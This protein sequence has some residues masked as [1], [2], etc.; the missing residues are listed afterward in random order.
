VGK[1]VCVFCGGAGLTR[2][3]VLPDWLT[4]A[5]IVS[6]ESATTHTRFDS[7]DNPVER[8]SIP[9]SPGQRKVRRFCATCNGG[10]M[11]R[12]ETATEPVLTALI[13]GVRRDLT[14]AE[15]ETLAW[16]I[17]KTAVTA[18]FV[19]PFADHRQIPDRQATW[20][21]Q[22]G[23]PAPEMQI[24]IA[25]AA[26]PWGVYV[27]PDRLGLGFPEQG[28]V[29]LYATTILLERAVL[30][31]IGTTDRT[32]ADFPRF[33]G[34]REGLRRIWPKP[35]AVS[36]PR[37]QLLDDPTIIRLAHALYPMREQFRSLPS[38]RVTR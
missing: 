1:R 17:A 8:L 9:E 4:R 34:E 10:W 24:F 31:V 6:F 35:G 18:Q 21:Y 26:T 7:H 20:I 22:R 36:L 33:P 12:L 27:A 2:E 28:S 13:T 19:S 32:L 29:V 30:H 16:W 37:A 23:R 11:S 14:A 5:G 3:H 15:V 25:Q 38:V